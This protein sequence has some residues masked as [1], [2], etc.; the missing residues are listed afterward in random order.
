MDSACSGGRSV[1]RRGDGGRDGSEAAAQ[2][3]G[4]RQPA[5]RSGEVRGGRGVRR[6]GG[7]C[8]LVLEG[9]NAEAALK[10][11]QPVGDAAAAALLRSVDVSGNTAAPTL[12]RRRDIVGGGGGRR[13]RK[14]EKR[15]RRGVESR[16]AAEGASGAERERRSWK[17]RDGSGGGLTAV[18]V[19]LLV[20]GC[21]VSTP[22]LAQ[23]ST[24]PAPAAP[25]ASLLR[26]RGPLACVAPPCWGSSPPATSSPT[27]VALPLL[28]AVSRSLRR[29]STG[30]QS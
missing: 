14:R 12:C 6:C 3:T 5:L 18:R 17:V 16:K 13:E 24:V 7:G 19:V 2:Q 27:R 8:G 28:G 22:A 9:K 23:S 15:Q 29:R 10:T 1:G 4:P 25:A 26:L 21:R 30:S 20:Q 11:R